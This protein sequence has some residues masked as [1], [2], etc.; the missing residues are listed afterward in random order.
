[1]TDKHDRFAC[2]YT[3]S[4]SGT[5]VAEL[6]T[7]NSDT[8]KPFIG[9][10]HSQT[11]EPAIGRYVDGARRG[12]G[13]PRTIRF[14]RQQIEV[15]VHLNNESASVGEVMVV[16]TSPNVAVLAS[17]FYWSR[18]G[19]V[20]RLVTED[21]QKTEQALAA[22]GFP[23]ATA[24]VLLVGLQQQPGVAAGI[25]VQLAAAGIAIRYS[26]VSWTDH[27]EAF[28]VFKTTDD[29]RALR[30]VQGSALME[31]LAREKTRHVPKGR[32]IR[33]PAASSLVV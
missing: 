11:E 6:E 17:S 20:V 1:M 16:A 31:E 32:A 24:S 25:G 10:R 7:E 9:R 19:A 2:D 23:C 5:A 29:D 26:Y 33:S 8:Q 12:I 21:P 13:R 15:V 28:A 22:A 18:D 27:N 30:L 4:E 14:A 3:H